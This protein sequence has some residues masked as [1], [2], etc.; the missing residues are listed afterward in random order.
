MGFNLEGDGPAVAQVGDS[1]V[2]TDPHQHVLF[3]FLRNLF[4]ELA[5]VVL[6]GLVGAVLAPHDGVH[7]QFGG[8]GAAP[9]NF[10]DVVEL[11]LFQAQRGPRELHLGGGGSVFNRVDVELLARFGSSLAHLFI[12]Q[13]CVQH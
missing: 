3:H 10:H 1:G 11:V 7:G 4:A 12:S 9:Q 2:F 6:G 5:Q 13:K 8:G